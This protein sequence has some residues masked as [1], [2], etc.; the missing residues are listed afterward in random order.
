MVISITFEDPCTDMVMIDVEIKDGKSEKKFGWYLVKKIDEILAEDDWVKDF[1]QLRWRLESFPNTIKLFDGCI[2]THYGDD[3]GNAKSNNK[4][5]NCMA[6]GIP[7]I[8]SPTV[9]Y[10][11]TMNETGFKFLV[12]RN[13]GDINNKVADEEREK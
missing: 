8:V 3:R 9:S 4:L 6:I 1:N 12:C 11:T 2:L 5:L 10:E 13:D 7:T